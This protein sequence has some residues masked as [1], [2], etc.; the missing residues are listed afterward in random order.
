[1]YVLTDS[2]QLLKIVV[3]FS[4]RTVNSNLALKSGSSKHGNA[5]RACTGLKCVNIIRDALK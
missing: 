5:S 4:C 1:S 3:S 2:S